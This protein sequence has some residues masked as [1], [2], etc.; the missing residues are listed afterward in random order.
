MIPTADQVAHAV[1]AASRH[2][3]VDPVDVFRQV[4]NK[5]GDLRNRVSRA[6]IYALMAIAE[7]F[8][9]DHLACRVLGLTSN[10][11]ATTRWQLDKRSLKWWEPKVLELVKAAIPDPPASPPVRERPAEAP[12]QRPEP[13]IAPSPASGP[14]INPPEEG[15]PANAPVR[16]ELRRRP[17]PNFGTV[18]GM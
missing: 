16:N 18:P 6:M 8:G 4:R 12:T 1:V 5:G 7:T 11:A 14:A 15:R 9:N 2:L 3:E 13:A 10:R 17:T